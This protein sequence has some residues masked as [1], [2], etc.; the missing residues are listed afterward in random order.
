MG[1]LAGGIGLGL[2]ILYCL[3]YYRALG[4]VVIASLLMSG[5]LVYGAL[6][7]LGRINGYTLSLAGIAGFIVAIGITADSFVVFFERLKDEVKDGRTVRSA[8]PRAWI[9]ARRTILSAD[10]VSFLAAAVLYFLAIGAVKG[11]AFTLGLSTLIDVLVVFL[12]THPLVATLARWSAFSSPR[13]SGL[14]NMRS[15]KA[16]VAAQ[17]TTNP[18]GAVR[19][20]ES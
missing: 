4:L 1:L 13:M 6:V 3:F 8:I 5:A 15:D 16:I 2:V 9:R 14:G 12:F 10:T 20:K 17:A 7:E 11:F 18:L 19:P